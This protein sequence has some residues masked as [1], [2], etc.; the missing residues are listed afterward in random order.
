MKNVLVTGANGQLSECIKKAV[1]AYPDLAI[2]FASIEDLDITDAKE[3]SVEMESRS[4]K[5]FVIKMVAD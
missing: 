3:L 1:S 2:Q 5:E 4:K